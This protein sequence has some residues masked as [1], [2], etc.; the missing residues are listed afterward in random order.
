VA[1]NKWTLSQV[2]EQM[3]QVV[4]SRSVD[5]KNYGVIV[6]PE[7]LLEFIPEMKKLIGT[8][9]DTLAHNAEFEALE[10]AGAKI[11]YVKEHLNGEN[12]TAF[13]S[14]PPSIQAQLLADRD[15]HGNV[16]VSKIDTEKL[17]IEAIELKLKALKK[18]GKYSGKFSAQGHFFGYEGRC[19]APSNLDADYCYALGFTASYLAAA[20]LTGYLSSV[21]DL[22]KP[23][24][25]W[26]AGGIP[27]TMMM[28]LERRHGKDKPV[29]QKAMVDLGGKP[30]QTLV[31]N[32]A[33][34]AARDEYL[35]PGP[36]QY[37]GPTKVADQVPVTLQLER[38]K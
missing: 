35:S 24:A 2:T 25:Q 36:I 13:Q 8:L 20:G 34:W 22:L 17:L 18:D 7:G 33:R 38:G 32:R 27:L 1:A 28:N 16:Q 19:A 21:R 15:P 3:A 14:L 12:L 11:E 26:R 4:V 5:G 29:I 9:N 37:W 6:I 10:Y 23:A 31:K 30:F